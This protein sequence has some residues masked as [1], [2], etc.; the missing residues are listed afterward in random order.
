MLRRGPPTRSGQR[1]AAPARPR[2]ACSRAARASSAAPGSTG[3]LKELSSTTSSSWPSSATLSPCRAPLVSARSSRRSKS[4]FELY[5]ASS[6]AYDQLV[7]KPRNMRG[8]DGE[9]GAAGRWL[10]RPV[11][12]SVLKAHGSRSR[13]PAANVGPTMHLPRTGPGG[14]R[15]TTPSLCWWCG[16]RCRVVGE[17]ALARQGRDTKA[18][19]I[20][21]SARRLRDTKR[22]GAERG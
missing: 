8:V 20:R 2:H 17:V 19:T 22:P 14:L 16:W 3:S 5:P 6:R 10:A 13:S 7:I 12:P 11:A 4:S 9:R 18:A 15:S 1:E 21:D